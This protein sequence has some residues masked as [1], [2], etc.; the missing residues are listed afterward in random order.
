VRTAEAGAVRARLAEAASRD[1]GVATE[2]DPVVRASALAP[3]L[4][5]AAF[6]PLADL[7][8]A[9][10]FEATPDS[11]SAAAF[12]PS[13]GVELACEFCRAAIEPVR[14]EAADRLAPAPTP[15]SVPCCKLRLAPTV[16]LEATVK[17]SV[18]F[19]PAED[20]A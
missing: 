16:R 13:A 5:A 6:C 19:F 7:A 11:E 18:A 17:L 12:F 4:E 8:F 20:L 9:S 15:S 1:S 3:L 2:A 10:A 14:T